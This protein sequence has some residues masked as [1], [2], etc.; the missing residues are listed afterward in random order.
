MKAV[1]SL[2]GGL[3]ST[4]LLMYLLANGYDEIRA[5]SF[6]Y[7]QKHS[8][9]L[10][11]VKKNIKFLQGKGYNVTHQVINLRDV[12]SDSAS[13]L[14]EG[15][16]EIPKGHYADETMKSTVI[17]NR[18]VIFSSIIYGKA[19]GWANK[20]GDN[21]VITLGIHAGDHAIYPDCTPESHNVAKYLFRISNWNSE[22][23]DYIAPFE[24]ID[25]GAVLKSGLDAMKQL[26][27]TEANI[28]S[29]LK[30]TH[31][32]Y[33]PDEDGRSCG[34]CG[35]CRERLEAFENNNMEDPLDYIARPV[36]EKMVTGMIK[37]AK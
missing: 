34:E 7:G 12:F 33:N 17:E 28:N 8:I 24:N 11:K 3:D 23:V 27:F 25:K 15:G 6:D 18:N 2:S 4:C 20:T 5:F 26:Q 32:C 31:T 1:I 36:T 35:S 22:R 19:L 14:H 13:S 37:E 21:V 9:E 16:D 30:N 10:K 29:V